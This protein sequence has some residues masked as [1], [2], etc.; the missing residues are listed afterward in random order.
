MAVAYEREGRKRGYQPALA[1]EEL[2]GEEAPPTQEGPWISSTIFS[3]GRTTF[4]GIFESSTL[5]RRKNLQTGE[6][7]YELRT[8]TF[9]SG[10]PRE[11]IQR[12]SEQ[13]FIGRL[14]Q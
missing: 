2:G 7:N 4:A 10:K 1:L 13:E 3:T 8:L 14:R 6:E 5:S 9:T 12:F 11:T